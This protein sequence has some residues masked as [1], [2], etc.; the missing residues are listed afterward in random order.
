[1]GGGKGSRGTLNND[2]NRE[3]GYV[4]LE[5]GPKVLDQPY[6]NLYKNRI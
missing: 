5:A 1:M 3:C 2:L 6:K 4:S